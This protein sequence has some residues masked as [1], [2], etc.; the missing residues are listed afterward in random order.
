MHDTYYCDKSMA[1]GYSTVS[2]SD[3]LL[4]RID[5]LIKNAGFSTRAG[6]IQ[7]RLRRAIEKDEL[8]YGGE[9]DERTTD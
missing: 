2:I 6:Y 9:R 8:R 7:D 4:D 3:L 1:N 5:I